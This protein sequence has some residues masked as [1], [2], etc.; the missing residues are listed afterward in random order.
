MKRRI[1]LWALSG[2]AVA[3]GWGLYAVA[4]WPNPGLGRSTV[5]AITAPASFLLGRTVPLAYY[6]FLLANA[7]VYALV[8]L[9]AELLRPHHR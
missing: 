1:A 4:T 7:A 6:C 9:G 5:V 8:G 3:G 2:L